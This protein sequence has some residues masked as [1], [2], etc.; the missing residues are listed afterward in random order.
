MKKILVAS[1]LAFSALTVTPSAMALDI[2]PSGFVDFI[3]TLSD[4]TDLGKNGAEGRFDTSGEL[5]VESNL[6]DGIMM[7]FDADVN[8]S[9]GGGDSARLE[10]I[11]LKWDIQQNMA[12]K[13]GVFNNKF[14]FERED[15][16]DLYQITHGQLW[17]VW[18]LATQEEDGNNLQ[19]LEFNYQLQKVN[20]I[21]GFLNDLGGIPEENSV[22]IGAEIDAIQNMNITVGLV[23]QDQFFENIFDVFANYK[24]NK[25]LFGGEILFADEGIDSGFMLMTNYQFS[26]KFS[27]TVRY[28]LVTY[29][30]AFLADDTWSLTVAGLYSISK[31]LFANA[32]IRFN[33]DPN[34]ANPGPGTPPPFIGEGDG[35]TARIELLATF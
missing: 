13:G 1:S 32:E 25:F 8:P 27:G 31:N 26:S 3:W 16:P 23:T 14:T 30:S 11:F 9:S 2:T 4:G 24:W 33:D 35:T 15:A 12:L 19:G 20:L 17:D 34:S 7:R 29:D 5:D 6:K 28:D 22:E 18:N 21:V 10:Q